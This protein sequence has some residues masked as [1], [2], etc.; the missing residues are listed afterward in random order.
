MGVIY[1]AYNPQLDRKIA[2]KLVRADVG[3]GGTNSEPHTRLLR[4]A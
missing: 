4:E 2:L 1:A 3:G